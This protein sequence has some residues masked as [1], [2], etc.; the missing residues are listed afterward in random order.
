MCLQVS[1][2]RL[3]VPTDEEKAVFEEC[4]RES[5]WYRC[6][7]ININIAHNKSSFDALKPKI[8]MGS[9]VISVVLWFTALPYAVVSMVATQA[10]VNRGKVL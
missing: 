1:L 4:N 9:C 5:F 2:E 6:K 8:T 10:M 3:Y 7:L